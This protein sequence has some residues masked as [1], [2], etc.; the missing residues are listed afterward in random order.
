MPFKPVISIN[1]DDE[2]F[3]SFVKI[4]DQYQSKLKDTDSEWSKAARTMNH[5]FGDTAS[6]KL[7]E[8]ADTL[9]GMNPS[10]RGIGS[11]LIGLTRHM[12][13]FGGAIH[14]AASGAGMLARTIKGIVSDMTKLALMGAGGIFAFDRLASS[15]INMIG[16]A[17]AIN[18]SAGRLSAFKIGA[19]GVAP[20]NLPESVSSAM[21]NPAS[22]ALSQMV[23][24]RAQLTSSQALQ[25]P[26]A[27]SMAVIQQ[28][29]DFFTRHRNE[30][31][32]P[33]FWQT[34]PMM[35]AFRSLGLSQADVFR[36]GNTSQ[37][38]L[39]LTRQTINRDSARLQMPVGTMRELREFRIDL[40]LAGRTIEVDLINRLRTLG[41]SLGGVISSLTSRFVELVNDV[42]TKPHID[43]FRDFLDRVTAFV[44]SP[45]FGADLKKLE[46][47]IADAAS[48]IVSIAKWLGAIAKSIPGTPPHGRTP[49]TGP[50]GGK[51]PAQNF[52]AN[53]SDSAA[54]QAVEREFGGGSIIWTLGHSIDQTGHMI[55]LSPSVPP[56]E[57]AA[58]VAN[59][60]PAGTL[61]AD[62]FAESGN[63]AFARNGNARGAFQM[64]PAAVARYLHG[65]NP[66]DPLAASR[67]EAA[68][69]AQNLA[70][71]RALLPIG[72][73]AQHLEL[74]K[75]ANAIGD[76]GLIRA[77]DEASSR[78]QS[79]DWMKFIKPW[80]RQD[81]V[82][83]MSHLPNR[84]ALE[85]ANAAGQIDTGVSSASDRRQ[86][87]S[88]LA[89][90]ARNTGRLVAQ[91]ASPK[92]VVY[93]AQTDVQ[94]DLSQQAYAA[95]AVGGTP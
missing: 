24:Q 14:V 26:V 13:V 53:M 64:L 19:A 22:I 7:H 48:D 32:S 40:D 72:T 85:S 42:L 1:V 66:L 54:R 78:G 2:Q 33:Q 46:S 27:A 82:R 80:A 88:D 70:T 35:Q 39:D 84:S 93:K 63:N 69:L 75:A 41:P 34:S 38:D 44:N 79:S 21:A 43:A 25:H 57:R 12:G 58:E 62:A 37:R 4:F 86:A 3:R 52:N 23:L 94:S 17:R 71:A 28:A 8:F 74:M 81:V 47:G 91:T 15:G 36:I 45:A 92:R 6:S 50:M 56:A 68:Q 73:L 87:A 60:L 55:M 30:I 18:T 9:S 67:G 29:H 31:G 95:A 65:G 90:V 51:T 49:G 5:G 10:I 76:Q 11:G 16:N 61:S 89:A 20:A 59:G 83:F 77:F